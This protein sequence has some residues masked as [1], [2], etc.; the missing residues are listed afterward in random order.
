MRENQ[1]TR[2]AVTVA[3]IVVRD[4]AFLLV[5]EETRHGIRLNQPAGHLE[6]GETLVDAAVR[7]TLEETGYRVVPT[8]LVGIYRWQRNGDRRDVH[9]FCVRRRRGRARVAPHARSGH[10]AGAVASLRRPG[11]ASRHAPES[12]R[13]AVRR[14]LPRRAAAPARSR[15]GNVMPRKAR[16]IVGMSGGVD[17]SVAAWL[18]KQQGFDVV[19]LFMKNWED[20]DTDE[21]CTSRADLVDAAS[22]ADVIGIELEAVNFAA[23]V[24]RAGVRAFP[25]R[26]RRRTHAEPGR[27]LQQRDQVPRVPR[28][29]AR[30]GRRPHRDRP[31]RAGAPGRRGRRAAEG[32]R[33]DE[34]PELLPA[35][36]DAG[37]TRAGAVSAR[38]N[39]QARSARDRAPRR[40]PHLGQEGLDGHLLHRRAAVSR[41]PREA[42]CRGRP[43]RSKR[44][45]ARVVGR[46]HGLAY[47]TLGQRQGLGI[48]GTREGS[49]L[50]WFV[51]GKDHGRNV[52]VVVQG[53]DH[54]LLYRM[55]VEA[56]ELHWIAGAPP[57][58]MALA[59]PRREDTLPDARRGVPCRACRRPSLPRELR[60]AAMGADPWAVSGAVRG[61]VC[62][63]GG[64][65]ATPSSAAEAS[66]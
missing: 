54:P 64:V 35:P 9:S 31:L 49:D 12:A 43:G 53:H 2:P 4:G 42:I 24:P 8:A 47:Y 41:L 6:A 3:T 55:E 37:A 50:P 1:L 44:R 32:R 13:A 27:A 10:S 22:V 30:H 5:E 56:Q 61:D 15:D 63:G 40:H 60:L 11:R 57:D 62:L 38:G 23:R 33:R 36:A 45:T 58:D 21:Y 7:E 29:C 65:I 59:A 46:H 25:A 51:A 14:R 52:L 18:L 17:S 48:G 66:P 34:G 19:G 26:I 16:V 28:S 39:R 20:D